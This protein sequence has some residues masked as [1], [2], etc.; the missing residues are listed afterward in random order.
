MEKYLISYLKNNE[1]NPI[2]KKY[3][4]YLKIELDWYIYNFGNHMSKTHSRKKTKT[5]KEKLYTLLQ[6][7]NATYTQV[8]SQN[9]KGNILS[10][11]NHKDFYNQI[12]N[13]GYNVYSSILQPVGRSKIIG[14]KN[15]IDLIKYK[16]KSIKNGIFNDLY[17]SKFF[18]QIE[19]CRLNLIKQ[20]SKNNFKALFL[21]TDQYFESK[22]LID[23]FQNIQRPSFI[24]SHGLPG[25][26]S[27]DVD[28]RSDY[29]MVWG[30]KIKENYIKAG[31]NSNKILV[32]GNS[33]YNHF[34]IATQLRNSTEDI[35]IIPKSSVLWHQHEWGNPQLTDRSMII[36]YLYSVQQVLM[37]LGVRSVR[38]RPHPAINSNWVHSFIDPKFYIRDTQNL[39]D[40]LNRSTLVI[41]ATSSVIFESLMYGVNYIVYEPLVEGKDLLSSNLVPPFDGS[42]NDIVTTHSEEDLMYAIKNKCVTNASVITNYMQPFDISK[43]KNIFNHL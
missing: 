14:D 11:V 30:D 8:S 22:L 10:S 2:T 35:L 19:L 43:I 42:D 36:L 12:S 39:K 26:Y 24:F 13:I 1:T 28:N 34:Q 7:I 37:K 41:G 6:Y 9:V 32:T 40:S 17:N 21:Y 4:D 16:N 29:L 25:I 3:I 5:V 18:N 33:K 15:I 38:Y 31:F 27:L 23:V 20:F